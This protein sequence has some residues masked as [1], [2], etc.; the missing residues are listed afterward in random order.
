MTYPGTISRSYGAG[1][2]SI[3]LRLNPLYLKPYLLLYLYSPFHVLPDTLLLLLP[4][5]SIFFCLKT[6]A[7]PFQCPY[8][9]KLG[10]SIPLKRSWFLFFYLQAHRLLLKPC[11]GGRWLLVNLF[12]SLNILTIS[13]IPSPERF[14]CWLKQ[15]RL[16]W[17][18]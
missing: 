11:N 4:P 15:L 6:I 7:H 9:L 17:S 13:R 8:V 5:R 10:R 16:H 12:P 1:R 18:V 3:G 14:F 2:A